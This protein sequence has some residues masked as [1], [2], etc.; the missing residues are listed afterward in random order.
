M[1]KKRTAAEQQ[2]AEL[3]LRT[4]KD[5]LGLSV[6]FVTRMDSTTQHLEVVDGV[7]PTAR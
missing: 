2:V 7:V 6:S 5:A 1:A 3:L 4:A